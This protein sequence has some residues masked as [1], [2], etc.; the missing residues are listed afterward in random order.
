[1]NLDDKEAALAA[2]ATHR[3]EIDRIDQEL[4]VLLNDRARQSLAIRHLKPAAGMTLTDAK[5]EEEI[6]KRL[7]ARS[8]GPLVEEDIRGIYEPLLTVMKSCQG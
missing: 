7:A 1:M 6:I 5:R 8:A 2:I 4:I 3:Q